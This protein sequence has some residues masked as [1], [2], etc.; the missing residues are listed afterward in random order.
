M[1][2][3]STPD[4]P[5]GYPVMQPLSVEVASWAGTVT[6]VVYGE[7]DMATAPALLA[8]LEH[9]SG[10]RAERLVFE[11]AGLTFADCSGARLLAGAGLRSPGASQPV[12][13]HVR[14]AVRRV[15]ELTGL[16]D[17]CRFEP[18]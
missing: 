14:P 7:L 8:R 17:L 9:L 16:G 2:N 18:G 1:P 12:L 10:L 4:P 6:V 3:T 15:L 13:R 11:L 5:F